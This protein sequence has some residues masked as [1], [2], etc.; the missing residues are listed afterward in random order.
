[1]EIDTKTLQYCLQHTTTVQ[2]VLHALERET[3][4]RTLH[5]QMLS[6]PYQGMLLQLISHMIRPRRVLEVGTFTGYSAI[7][8][9]QGLTEDG[10]LFTLESNDEHAPIV[11]KHVHAAGLE[12]KIRLILGDAI[13]LIPQFDEIFDLIFLDAGKLDYVRHYELCLPKLRP[14][15]FLL[16]D[17]VLWD[18][19]VVHDKKDTTAQALREFNTMVQADDR[20]DNLLLPL[21]DG[22][23]LIRKR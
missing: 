8:L 17:N 23:M 9:A 5:P 3:N 4:I 15:G 10:L 16:A 13:V 14:G 1:M 2:P 12:N 11:R 22:V 21:R 18:G 19:K 6:G 20:V 7:C